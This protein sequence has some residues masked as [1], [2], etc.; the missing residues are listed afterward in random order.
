MTIIGATLLRRLLGLEPQEDTGLILSS[1]IVAALLWVYHALVLRDDSRAAPAVE[2]QARIRR[3]YWYLVAAVGLLAFLIGLGG[4]ISVAINALNQQRVITEP[5]RDQLAWFTAALI[6]GII[7]W[8]IPWRKI[9]IEVELPAPDGINARNAGSRRYY[10]YGFILLATITFLSST[11][12]LVYSVLTRLLGV[13]GTNINFSEIAQA[14]AFA[15]IAVLVWVY[16]GSLLR[17]DREV[18]TE[19][20]PQE[21]KAPEIAVLDDQDGSM[22]RKL[23]DALETALP[24]AKLSAVGLTASAR[25][26][27][28]NGSEQVDTAQILNAADIIIGPWTMATPFA[29]EKLEDDG[30]IEAIAA[31]P[32]KKLLI[33]RAVDHWDWAG[34]EH[35]Q[36]A[37]VINQVV[38]AVGQIL[39]GESVEVKKP[40][41]AA[42][43]ILMVIG[44]FFLIL[45]LLTMIVGPRL[46]G[47]FY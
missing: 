19:A 24:A 14:I 20:M 3:V 6:A 25:L 18:L 17:R 15:L 37:A 11:I 13:T 27:L 4:N 35:Q 10:L 39:A 38:Q 28:N 36:D 32:A 23:H 44:A 2:A 42:R 5:L 16:H 47:L 7:V 12:F 41:G 31:S 30:A 40:F 33:P 26:G 29:G 8:L 43:I 34:V 21:S 46:L 1:L 9:Q 22:G 45:C